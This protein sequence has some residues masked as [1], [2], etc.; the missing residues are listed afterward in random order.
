MGPRQVTGVLIKDK[1]VIQW[2]RLLA[3]NAE[4]QVQFLV[5]ELDSTAGN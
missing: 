3:P 2:L 4:G 1:F 5:R